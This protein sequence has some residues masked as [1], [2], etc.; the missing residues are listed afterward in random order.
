MTTADLEIAAY[1][2]AHRI[3]NGLPSPDRATPGGY[4]SAMIDKIA[5]EIKSAF[6]V[7]DLASSEP[8]AS[9]EVE[10]VRHSEDLP[11]GLQQTRHWR[12]MRHAFDLGGIPG[13]AYRPCLK[14]GMLYPF[15]MHYTPSGEPLQPAHVEPTASDEAA[16]SGEANP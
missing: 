1:V 14:C 16:I 15:E 9:P 3:F 6:S 12:Q 13:T 8:G 10:S 4:R 2:A 11:P 5:E 7:H